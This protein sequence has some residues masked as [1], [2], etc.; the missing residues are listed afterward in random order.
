MAVTNNSA[1]PLTNYEGVKLSVGQ[2]T[3]VKVSRTFISKLDYPFSDCRMDTTTART[4]DNDL[5]KRTLQLNAYSVQLCY[6]LCLQ[7]DFIS[8]QCNCSDP[9]LQQYDTVSPICKTINNLNC[10]KS[11]KD[12]FDT[13]RITDR[14]SQYC[15]TPCNTIKYTT[16]TSSSGYPTDYYFKVLA[17]TPNLQLKFKPYLDSQGIN[18]LSNLMSLVQSSVVKVNVFYDDLNYISIAD[19]QSITID[20]LFGTIG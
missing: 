12:K 9:T 8:K 11:V 17:A 2:S 4:S 10:V 13:N 7:R 15:P 5:Y 14:C 6:D 18:N 20:T 1:Y 3:D 19:S 16:T